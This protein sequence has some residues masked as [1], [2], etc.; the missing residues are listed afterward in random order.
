MNYKVYVLKHKGI[1]F[2]VGCTYVSLKR[3][4]QAHLDRHSKNTL[5]REFVEACG[6]EDISIH[7]LVGTNVKSFAEEAEE[8]YIRYFNTYEDGCN[9]TPTGKGRVGNRT[10]PEKSLDRMRELEEYKQQQYESRK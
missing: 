5:V 3:R 4:L 8:R 7:V 1:P 9:L 6:K 2:Y 10:L